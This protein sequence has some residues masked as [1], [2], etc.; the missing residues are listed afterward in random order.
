MQYLVECVFAR[1]IFV[2]RVTNVTR[3]TIV[4]RVTNVTRQKAGK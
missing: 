3:V 1:V 4:T 2:T